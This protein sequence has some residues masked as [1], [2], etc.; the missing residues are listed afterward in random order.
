MTNENITKDVALKLLSNV[1]ET[2]QFWCK[3]GIALSNLK[4]LKSA[5]QS[6]SNETFMHH[7]NSEKN[8]F[9]NWINDIIG[10]KEL[11]DKLRSLQSKNSVTKEVKNRI[12]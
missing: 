3:D 7:V 10:D 9:Y 1:P 12:K 4:D 6:M 5:L 2:N 11:A 8:D